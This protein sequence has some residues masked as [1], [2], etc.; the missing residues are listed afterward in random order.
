MTTTT[1]TILLEQCELFREGGLVGECSPCTGSA[2]EVSCRPADNSTF[3]IN[4]DPC[5]DIIE[6][7]FKFDI[8]GTTFADTFEYVPGVSITDDYVAP[9]LIPSEG[10]ALDVTTSV[11]ASNPSANQLSISGVLDICLTVK[12]AELVDDAAIEG[13]NFICGLTPSVDVCRLILGQQV[14]GK[15]L[16]D[17]LKDP[18]VISLITSAVEE[19]TGVS[20]DDLDLSQLE[21]PFALFEETVEYQCYDADGISIDK[22]LSKP[23]AQTAGAGAQTTGVLAIITGVA[24][25]LMSFA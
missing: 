19:E 7:S 9:T 17:I 14:C 3:S 25:T 21:L 1:A 23:P 22:K 12:T 16:S 15:E 2:F 11:T 13:L 4:L 6:A 10:V 18:L 24:A 20:S 5:N 8:M